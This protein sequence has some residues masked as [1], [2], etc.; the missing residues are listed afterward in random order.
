MKRHDALPASIEAVRE[1]LREAAEEKYRA[2]SSALLPG[3]ENVLGVRLPTLRKLAGQ[4]AKAPWAREWLWRGETRSFEESM[5][6]GFVTAGIKTES[7]EER[8][9]WVARFVP[10]I[11]NWSVCD[12]FCVSLKDTRT[13]RA[14]TF[15]FLAPYLQSNREFEA[16]FGAVMLLNH[17]VCGEWLPASLDA[18]AAVPAEAYYARMAVAWAMQTFYA[19]YPETVEN[20]LAQGQLDEPT[21]ALTIRKIAQSLKTQPEALARLQARMGKR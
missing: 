5:L 12:S 10:R 21:A 15:A 20:F 7:L 3:T 1:L 16:R 13:D 9:A 6:A 4:I 2:F 8:L 18:L 17:F 11:D 14:R 19:A